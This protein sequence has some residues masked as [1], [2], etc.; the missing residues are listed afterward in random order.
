M[1]EDEWQELDKRVELSGRQKQDYLIK[2]VLHQKIVVICNQVQFD[3]LRS[4]L[5]EILNELR[6][7]ERADGV[8]EKTLAP[9]RTAGKIIG[10]FE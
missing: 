4:T 5:D 1:P 8:Y 10:R 2:S 7:I 9:I 6:R 3:R